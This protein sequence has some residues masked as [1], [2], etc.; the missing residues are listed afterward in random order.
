[1]EKIEC[2]LLGRKIEKSRC[3]SIKGKPD[4]KCCLKCNYYLLKKSNQKK[5]KK[6]KSGTALEPKSTRIWRYL[7]EITALGEYREGPRITDD[8]FCELEKMLKI[9]VNNGW[10]KIIVEA[11][12]HFIEDLFRTKVKSKHE[13]IKDAVKTLKEMEVRIARTD[14]KVFGLLPLDIIKRK[15][16]SAHEEGTTILGEDEFPGKRG[17]ARNFPLNHLVNELGIAYEKLTGERATPPYFDGKTGK[18]KNIHKGS[19][20]WFIKYILNCINGLSLYPHQSITRS[21]K[22][23]VKISRKEPLR[24]LRDPDRIFT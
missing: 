6:R 2:E 9:Q 7:E 20:I 14:K 22:H 19:F 4:H 10:R 18:E 8:Q 16:Q 17:P 11:T 13:E 12:D 5:R 1:M 23:H 24:T 21:I 3:S 15:I